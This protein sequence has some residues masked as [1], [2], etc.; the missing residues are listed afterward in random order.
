MISHIVL[1]PS[2]RKI[3]CALGETV[4]GALEAAGY[5]LPNNCRAGDCGECKVRVRSGDFDQGVVLDMALS[6][7]ERLEGYGLMCMA[8]PISEEL[9]IE[10]GDDD[11][12]RPKLFPPCRNALFVVVGKH[13]CAAGVAE[14]RLRPVGSPIRYW[15]GQYVT[16]GDELNGVPYRAYSMANVPR[17]DGEIVL[18]VARA[19]DGGTSAWV[20]DVLAVGNQVKVNG[21]YGSFVGDPTVDA[22]LLCLAAG[23]GV[24]PV[25]A[26]AE[27]ALQRGFR[28]PVSFLLSARRADEVYAH[29]MLSWWHARHRN[30]NY[31]VTLTR[32]ARPGY[33]HGRVDAVLPEL[34]PDLSDHSVFVAGSPAFVDACLRT[35]RK[36][37]AQEALIHS[38]GF[39]P[40]HDAGDGPAHP[41]SD[42][43]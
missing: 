3:V 12:A 20:H 16:L 4:L 42:D 7:E 39:F 17:P 11:D 5:T 21:A 30:F 1:Y 34:M 18:Q 41:A 33:L 2:G 13:F 35:V 29:G 22:P 24:A 23:T 28:R 36:L 15:P 37:G 10:W 38:E 9:E 26:L 8:K 25:L 19:D 31:Q 6:P 27:A 32:E 14:L 43:G 40:Q